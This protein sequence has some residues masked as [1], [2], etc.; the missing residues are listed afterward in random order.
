M[1]IDFLALA[2]R[3]QWVGGG[4]GN[5]LEGLALRNH[6]FRTDAL[7]PVIE[8]LR[9]SCE[10]NNTTSS[11]RLKRFPSSNG[12]R[13]LVYLDISGNLLGD[14]GAAE[15]IGLLRHNKRLRALDLSFNYISGGAQVANALKLVMRSNTA[16]ETLRLAG[17]AIDGRGFSVITQ[18]LTQ[19][20]YVGSMRFLDLSRNQF[21]PDAR[22]I[23]KLISTNHTL[24]YLSLEGNILSE[25]CGMTI[26]LALQRNSTLCFLRLSGSTQSE[27][28]E[29]DKI[30]SEKRIWH[31]RRLIYTKS[32]GDIEDWQKR[33]QILDGQ[34]KEEDEENMET[35]A[36]PMSVHRWPSVPLGLS[37]PLITPGFSLSLV[38]NRSVSKSHSLSNTI[39]TRIYR[40]N[41][42]WRK[43]PA[44]T[45]SILLMVR[46]HRV[47]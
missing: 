27:L 30:F 45:Q 13:G 42:N 21:K 10:E 47:F 46:T 33:Q 6:E 3:S 11:Q 20:E 31:N 17:N 7:R 44:R 29:V 26:R 9:V 25:D 16:L 12:L 34:S 5:G 35:L 37:L 41:L 2:I 15:T 18:A 24:T 1:T 40:Y 4:G 36:P 38:R 28:R 32:R 14:A 22:D 39:P 43:H 23:G 8:L 19:R